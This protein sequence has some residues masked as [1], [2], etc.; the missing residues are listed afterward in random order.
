MKLNLDPGVSFILLITKEHGM[1]QEVL[2]CKCDESD[3]QYIPVALFFFHG[4][5]HQI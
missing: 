3:G 1:R 5:E 2:A 4:K